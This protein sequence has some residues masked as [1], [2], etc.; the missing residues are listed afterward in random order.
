MA[1]EWNDLLFAHWP[2]PLDHLRQHV[3]EQL[4]IETFDGTAWIGIT[5]FLMTGTR[6][7]MAPRALGM[8]FPELNVR[9]YVRS[10]ERPGI[11]FFSLDADSRLA[12]F[13]A[14]IGYHL[15]YYS[16]SMKHQRQSGAV[17]FESRRL[18]GTDPHPDVFEA[19][20]QPV[21]DVFEAV[22]GTH[23]HFLTERYVLFAEGPRGGLYA[24]H[25]HHRPWPL[26]EA[27]ADIRKNT[28]TQ[29][30]GFAL[31]DTAPLLHFARHLEVIAW[32][33]TP[34]SPA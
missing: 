8:R 18:R 1:M 30:I 14:R 16:A 13:A 10:G 24:G 17:H 22:P 25:I 31:P 20:Y 7:R 9:T 29:Q 28:M 2:V 15:P 33:L 5:P 23:E 12:V 32:Y 26:Q 21:G 27:E 6:P 19:Q 34:E 4:E 11:W 3:P